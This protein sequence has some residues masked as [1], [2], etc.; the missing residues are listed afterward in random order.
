[1]YTLFFIAPHEIKKDDITLDGTEARHAISVLRV[2]TGEIIRLADGL[3]NWVEGEINSIAKDSLTIS[4]SSRGIDRANVTAIAT[5][6]ALLKG[7]NQKAALD[8]LVQSGVDSI[9]PWRA[10][11]SIGAA[12]KSEK[13]Q[14][15]I[16]AAAKQS[17][18]S[19]IPI[20]LPKV[21]LHELSK[22]FARY[23][24]VIAL[25]EGASS[26]LTTIA[27]LEKCREVL[28]IVGPEGGL[29]EDEVAALTTAGA[30]VVCLGDPVIRADLAGALAIAAIHALTG[31]W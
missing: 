16:R 24:T 25:H 5:A 29:T 27:G 12:D 18:R 4:V 11:R 15:A 2:R 1:M 6:Q 17:R 26:K 19:R 14:E 13:W 10:F 8:Q 9:I 31:N 7:D 20:L 3:G 30:H 23:D 28:V 22:S 21:E